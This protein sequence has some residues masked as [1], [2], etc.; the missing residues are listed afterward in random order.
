MPRKE[1]ILLYI[2]GCLEIRF[3]SVSRAVYPINSIDMLQNDQV[4]KNRELKIN[5]AMS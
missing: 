3:V 4:V 5:R 1:N 2:L